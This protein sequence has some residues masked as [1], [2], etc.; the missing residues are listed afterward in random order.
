M[1]ASDIT[2]QRAQYEHALAILIGKPPAAFHLAVSPLNLVAPVLPGVPV[3]LP[4]QLLERRPD[5]AAAERRM[6]STNEQIG[7]ARAAY[8]PTLNLAASAGLEGSSILN[9]LTWPSRFWSVGPQLSETLFDGDD[10]EQ[11][12]NRPAQD[13]T[14]PSLAIGKLS[15]M[16]SSKSRIT[17]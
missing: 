7:I 11:L 14:P 6:A 13:M 10:A 2:V 9:W 15:S 4:A 1:V 8:Y 5:I 12:L 17:W 16:H 3:T